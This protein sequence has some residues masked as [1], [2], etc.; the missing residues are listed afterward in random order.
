[1][2]VG[3]CDMLPSGGPACAQKKVASG[4]AA[5]DAEDATQLSLVLEGMAASAN[6]LCP[7]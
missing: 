1:L 6:A 4:T 2:S 3:G 5:P 7:G